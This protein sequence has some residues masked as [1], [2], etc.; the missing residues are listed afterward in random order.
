MFFI[1]RNGKEEF[2]LRGLAWD[3]QSELRLGLDPEGH[4]LPCKW[5]QA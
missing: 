1:T 5:I 4:F 3:S 2:D